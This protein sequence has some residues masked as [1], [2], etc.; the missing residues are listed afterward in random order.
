MVLQGN[1][2]EVALP[3]LLQVY[4]SGRQLARLTV[5]HA[6]GPDAV[7]YFEGGELVHA[8]MGALTGV[9]AV[10][11]AL[12]DDHGSF[13]A[14]MGV[15]APRKTITQHWSVVVMEGL[16]RVDESRA[17]SR[18][19]PRP[20]VVAAG[21]RPFRVVSQQAS[22]S[23]T[24]PVA[25][26]SP[27]PSRPP[28]GISPRTVLLMAGAALLVL[29]GGGTLWLMRRGARVPAPAPASVERPPL[30]L[31]MVAALSGPS[32]ELGRQMKL[33][34]DTAFA[35]ANEAGGVAG[36]K[37][38]LVALDD[39]YE[40]ARTK[41]AMKELVENRHVFAVVGNVGTPTAEVAVPYANE[42]K[43]IFFGAFTGAGLLRKEPPDRYVLN[44]R[45]SYA[46]ETA[47]VVRWLVE[48][49]KV[50]P[51]EIAVFAQ[52][53]GFGDAGFAGV[54]KAL[55]RFSRAPDD[56][57]RVGFK[58]NTLEIE[59]AVGAIL[60]ARKTVRAVV[61]VAPY[62][63]AAKFI[64]ETKR[65]GL[66][67]IYTNVSFV[68]STALAEELRELGGAFASGVVVT[69]VVPPVD[70]SATAVLKYRDALQK[71]FP[72]EKPDF[73]SLEGYVVGSLLVEGLRRAGEPLTTERV[74]DALE[75]IHDLD[76]GIGTKLS[77]SISE[78]Q[79]SHRVWGTVLNDAAQYQVLDLE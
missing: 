11:A 58:R 27:S 61:M 54:A 48:V 41:E 24:V 55:R 31:G 30:V 50:K 12:E 19:Q 44:Y 70:S 2:D 26:A 1:L 33:G 76:L 77:F 37:L 73:V 4:C 25:A 52:Q 53:D 51:A 6:T 47:A 69:Q 74:V 7:F 43:T 42:K 22:A 66:D 60:K 15:S 9:D 59:D 45:A 57:L 67:A 29:F 28:G 38:D 68:G 65:Q 56:I 72:G 14:D 5:V 78:H 18:E 35:L 46:E 34:L 71:H 75:S 40:P 23:R 8:E 62:R 63:P 20:A 49:R 13:R 3:D 36:R 10:W 79:A 21:P 16:K 39:G 64:E 17:T 32:K